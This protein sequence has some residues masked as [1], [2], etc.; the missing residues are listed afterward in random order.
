[1]EMESIL[2]KEI[3]NIR[4]LIDAEIESNTEWLETT[5]GNE[6]ECIG[7]E[8]LAGI[9]NRAFEVIEHYQ[10]EKLKLDNQYIERTEKKIKKLEKQVRNLQK[11]Q[12]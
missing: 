3:L 6:V 2:D 4:K 7:V 11:A 12:V 9:L 8:N 10:Q 1:M 5:E